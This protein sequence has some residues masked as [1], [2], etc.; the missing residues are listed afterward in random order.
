MTNITNTTNIT[1]TMG[2]KPSY[3]KDVISRKSFLKN[4]L[5]RLVK[6]DGYLYPDP[7]QARLGRGIYFEND[8]KKIKAFLESKLN[9]FGLISDE[10][11]EFLEL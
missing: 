10:L 3:R 1:M 7:N 2:N 4:D 5:L 6:I 9:R 8:K 11:K